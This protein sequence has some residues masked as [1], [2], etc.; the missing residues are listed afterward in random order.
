MLQCPIC[1]ALLNGAD[2]CRRCRAELGKVTHLE[3]QSETL[4]GVAFHSLAL[5]DVETATGLL[6]R[7][8]V[9]HAKP[10]ITW[11]LSRIADGHMSSEN[12]VEAQKVISGRKDF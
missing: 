11:I 3:Q 1:K 7:A 5:G 4:A 12:S 6:R 8:Q 2:T 9:I 10:E